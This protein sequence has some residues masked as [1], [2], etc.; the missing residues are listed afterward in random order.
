M[1]LKKELLHA[2]R[3]QIKAKVELLQQS[4]QEIQNAANE[5]TKSSAG[6]KFETGRA[7]MHLEKEKLARQLAEQ[8][9]LLEVL[10]QVDPTLSCK[11]GRLGALIQTSAGHY[12][13]SVSLG[14]VIF[15]GQHYF[16]LSVAA[17][18]GQHLLKKQ[19]G[20]QFEFRGKNITIQAIQ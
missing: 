6:D 2:C 18:L 14:K 19:V 10:S 13:L 7:M 16:A 17:P 15:D 1:N 3:H 12:F 4:M 9:K 8:L 5:D 11:K 20:D